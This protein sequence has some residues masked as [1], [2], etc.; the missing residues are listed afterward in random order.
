MKA[1]KSWPEQV[2]LLRSRGLEIAD[3]DACIAALMRVNYYRL[4]GYA[5]RFQVDPQRGDNRFGPGSTF[6][7]ILALHDLDAQLRHLLMGP[8]TEVE[9]VL[10][11]AFAYVVARD[12][13][14]CGDYL[15]EGFYSGG[16]RGDSVVEACRRDL[17]RS[18]D[19]FIAHFRDTR[20]TDPYEGL[21]VWAAV[22]AFSFG[23]L[24]KC[25]ERVGPVDVVDFLNS[26]YDLAKTGLAYRL[27]ALVYLRNRCAHHGRLWNHFVTDA[28]PTPTN[29]R[30]KAKRQIGQFHPQSVTDVV[31][32]LDDIVERS[33]GR[34]DSLGAVADL[35]GSN[36]TYWGG[37]VSP[38]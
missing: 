16:G 27:R 30:N 24:S 13:S 10:R 11:T 12:A 9:L 36:S 18:K 34:P 8:L 5:R 3:E 21:L 35:A 25:I 23:T 14:P 15:A 4:S 29:V 26:E 32:S 33:L 17:D 7:G 22:E 20:A 37:I 31:A 1:W 6:E 28:G 19:H 38:K 2:D